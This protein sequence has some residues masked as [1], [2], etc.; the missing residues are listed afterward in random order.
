GGIVI[1]LLIRLVTGRNF[2][3][4]GP[5]LA[6]AAVV[7][8]FQWNTLWEGLMLRNLFSHWP[9]IAGLVFSSL[10]AL[11][12]LLGALRIFRSVPATRLRK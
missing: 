6:F 12:L 7:V 2:V 9:T 5:Y 11:S 4:F 8:L 3:A 1:G 10:M